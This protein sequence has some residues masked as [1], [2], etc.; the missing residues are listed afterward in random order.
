MMVAMMLP[1]LAPLLVRDRRGAVQGTLVALGYFTVWASAGV[2]AYALGTVL[3]IADRWWPAPLV[4]ALALLIAVIT[5]WTPWKARRLVCCRELVR[6]ARATWRD[7][8]LEGVRL[9]VQCCLCCAGLM[10]FLIVTGMMRR[11]AVMLV[12]ALIA[13]ERFAPRPR[14]VARA[15]GVLILVVGAVLIANAPIMVS[16]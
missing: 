6:Q 11:G 2:A 9:G 1:S 12:A 5:Q 8:L 15:A 3:V 14:L 13:L 16:P 10:T 4:A 7:A